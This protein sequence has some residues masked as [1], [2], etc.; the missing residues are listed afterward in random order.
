MRVFGYK[1]MDESHVEAFARGYYW[2]RCGNVQNER[3]TER[4][5]A[6][7]SHYEN[8]FRAGQEAAKADRRSAA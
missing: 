4:E 1:H 8:G 5:R 3:P 7:L 6:R 2:G